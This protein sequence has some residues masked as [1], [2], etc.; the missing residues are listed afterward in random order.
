MTKEQIEKLQLLLESVH[1][2][3]AT[4]SMADDMKPDW[5]QD[6]AESAFEPLD[7]AL[8][9]LSAARESP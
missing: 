5:Y 8:A 6:C 7:E 1:E 3:I 2:R 9:L 4:I